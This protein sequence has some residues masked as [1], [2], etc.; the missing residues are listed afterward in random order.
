MTIEKENE[1]EKRIRELLEV[2]NN[3][4]E[5]ATVEIDGKPLTQ[6]IRNQESE[7]NRL[8]QEVAQLKQD[9]KDIASAPSTVPSKPI[10]TPSSGEAA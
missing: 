10:D 6:I 2:I 4:S 9:I 1:L 3:S 5:N 7:I 8:K